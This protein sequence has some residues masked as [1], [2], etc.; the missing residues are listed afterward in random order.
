MG[1]DVKKFGDA[2][3]KPLEQLLLRETFKSLRFLKISAA[4]GLDVLADQI[5]ENLKAGLEGLIKRGVTV[6]YAG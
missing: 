5:P 4:I 3:L 2:E 6:Q 1:A